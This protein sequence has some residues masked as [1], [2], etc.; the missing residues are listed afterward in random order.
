M[1]MF[2]RFFLF[3]DSECG[4]GYTTYKKSIPR[5]RQP[6]GQQPHPLRRVRAS[7]PKGRAPDEGKALPRAP[8]LGELALRSND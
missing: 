6:C 1:E 5:Q 7:S 3:V 4:G 2:H 8:P